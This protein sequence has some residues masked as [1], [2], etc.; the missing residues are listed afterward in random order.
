MMAMEGSETSRIKWSS[1]VLC[2]RRKVSA[3]SSRRTMLAVRKTGRQMPSLGT[4][5]GRVAGAVVARS[6]VRAKRSI[7]GGEGGGPGAAGFL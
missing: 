2:P 1:T 5:Q 7:G 6:T 3:V 4:A